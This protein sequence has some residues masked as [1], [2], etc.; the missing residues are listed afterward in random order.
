MAKKQVQID[1]EEYDNRMIRDNRDRNKFSCDEAWE[2]NYLVKALLKQLPGKDELSFKLNTNINEI[3]MARITPNGKLSGKLAGLV[4]RQRNGKT[5]V[6][7]APGKQ[8][9]PRSPKQLEVADRFQHAV[10]YAKN[11]IRDPELKRKYELKAGKGRSA[12]NMALADFLHPPEILE[13]D[14]SGYS[15]KVGQT[16]RIT[17]TDDFYVKNVSI[18]IHR[19]NGKLVE[20]GEAK[21]TDGELIWIYEACA[22]TRLAGNKITVVASDYAGNK[23]LEVKS[24]I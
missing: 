22:T 10:E 3:T 6:S 23:T 5:F 16:I 13:V 1:W 18:Q 7:K 20:E 24:D 11:A 21:Q 19:Q 12:Y 9:S 2:V 4:F 14:L 15:G 17:V 8:T